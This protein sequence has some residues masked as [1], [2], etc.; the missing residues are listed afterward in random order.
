M[1]Y[2]IHVNFLSNLTVNVL[3]VKQNGTIK[4]MHHTII[5][6]FM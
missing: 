4:I 6:K 1:D 2:G 5:M 3:A